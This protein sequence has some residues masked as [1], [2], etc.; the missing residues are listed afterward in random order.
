MFDGHIL[1]SFEQL[2]LNF[3]ACSWFFVHFVK[4]RHLLQMVLSYCFCSLQIS[5]SGP[6]ASIMG[7]KSDRSVMWPASPTGG[8]K[9]LNSVSQGASFRGKSANQ[10]SQYEHGRNETEWMR[11]TATATVRFHI[12][13]TSYILSCVCSY[14]LLS[15]KCEPPQKN[16]KKKYGG[17]QWFEQ[18]L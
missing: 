16:I 17:K 18:V 1:K 7:V 12:C 6:S 13:W 5:R 3:I 8:S 15:N 11:Y 2:K 10:Q 14:C 9:Q 4:L